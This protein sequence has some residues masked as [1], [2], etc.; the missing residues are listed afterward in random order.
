MIE[1][2]CNP[3]LD[4]NT[5]LCQYCAFGPGDA[6]PRLVYHAGIRDHEGTYYPFLCARCWDAIESGEYEL[7]QA[8][9]DALK[10]DFDAIVLARELSH[11][12]DS[13]NGGRWG[14]EE[15]NEW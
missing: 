6:I 2:I 7:K 12:L 9:W 10:A 3:V 1:G 14:R 11:L 15:G 5:A 13:E 4:D 8:R